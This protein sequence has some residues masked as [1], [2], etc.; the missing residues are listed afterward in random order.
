MSEQLE[1]EVMARHYREQE[2]A[3][4]RARVKA[5]PWFLRWAGWVIYWIWREAT[6]MYWE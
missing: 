3:Q 6:R 4:A 2:L 1:A 5:S